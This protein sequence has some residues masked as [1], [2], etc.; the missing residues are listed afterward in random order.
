MLS[1]D[2]VSHLTESHRADLGIQSQRH[3]ALGASTGGS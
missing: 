1:R 2:D 3:T